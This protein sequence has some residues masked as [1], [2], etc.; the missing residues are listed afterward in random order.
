MLDIGLVANLS[1]IENYDEGAMIIKEGIKEPYTM[2]VVL[3]GKVAVY[4]DYNASGERQMAN[5][6]SGDFFG[7]M[8]LFLERPRCATVIALEPVTALKIC[9][10]NVMELYDQH[11]KI[12]TEVLD[13]LK[14]RGVETDGAIPELG[15]ML[16]KAK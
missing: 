13:V 2:Y 8:S 14:E 16:N 12:F 11:P 10:K 3:S 7:E 1:S 15:M 9:Q 4:K 5:L 6:E